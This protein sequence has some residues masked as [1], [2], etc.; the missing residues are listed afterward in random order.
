MKQMGY[1]RLTHP[2]VREDGELRRATWDEALERAAA[3]V[4]PRQGAERAAGVRPLQLLEG[5]ERDEL[6][7]PEVRPAGDGQQQHRSLQ[8]DLTRP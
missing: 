4:P 5:D 8:P 1:T 6:P 2:L 7:R 3:G